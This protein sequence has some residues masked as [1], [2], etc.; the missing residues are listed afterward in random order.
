MMK[1]VRPLVYVVMAALI[2]GGFYM[3]QPG[4]ALMSNP[5]ASASAPTAYLERNELNA[6]FKIGGRISELLVKEGDVVKKG[7]VIA[8]LQNDELLAKV[9]QAKAAVALAGGKI[10]EATG[11]VE[12]AKVKAEQGQDA[13]ALTSG[14]VEAQIAQAEAAVKAAQAKVDAMHAGARPEERK[15]AE[16]QLAATKEV[17][18]VAETNLQRATALFQ[19]GLAAKT[20]VDKANVSYQEAKAKYDAAFQQN[21]LVT[22]GPREEEVRAAEAQLEQAQSAL[23]LAQASRAQVPVRQ[24]DVKAAGAAQQ[25]AEGALQSAQSARQQAEAALAEA[26]TYL[27]YAELIAPADGVIIAQSAQLGEL[28]GSGFPVFTLQT[29]E[30]TWAKFFLTEKEL[31]GL[32]TGDRVEAT[33]VSTGETV[34][35]EIALISPGADFSVK[36]ASQNAGQTDI[37]SFGVKVRFNQLPESARA[38]MTVLWRGLSTSAAA[39]EP[40]AAVEGA[41]AEGQGE[42]TA[43]SIETQPKGE[44]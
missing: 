10:G 7:Q 27:G 2:G 28:V 1:V 4:T 35:G 32:K 43:Q 22:Q 8:R 15:Q 3:L 5:G 24:G 23:Q 21:E 6:S 19:E 29:A 26:Q 13:V 14:T 34:Q 25:Q 20:D 44:Q 17:L 31:P 30:E 12:T 18:A 38:G 41:A 42:D 36:K 33:L 37:R 9:E 11:A 40:A 39:A 16:I